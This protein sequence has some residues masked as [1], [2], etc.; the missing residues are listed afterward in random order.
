VKILAYRTKFK[1]S[2]VSVNLNF[3]KT[4][5]LNFYLELSVNA[6]SIVN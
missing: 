1:T 5:K 2:I 6:E 4:Y 3:E